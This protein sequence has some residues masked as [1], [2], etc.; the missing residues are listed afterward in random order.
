MKLGGN[1]KK[2]SGGDG[3]ISKSLKVR[4][5]VWRACECCAEEHRPLFVET[6]KPGPLADVWM[7]AEEEIGITNDTPEYILEF[8]NYFVQ[9]K[10]M[11]AQGKL[12]KEV[13]KIKRRAAEEAER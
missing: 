4:G 2:L 12:R 8:W 10:W 7:R 9:L 13:E 6:Q 11:E 3:K 5:M 1:K